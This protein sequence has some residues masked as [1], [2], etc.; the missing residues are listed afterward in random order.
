LC[1]TV[2][3]TLNRSAWVLF[4]ALVVPLTACNSELTSTSKIDDVRVRTMEGMYGAYLADHNN[5]PP[6]DE[7]AFRTYLETKQEN[8]KRAGLMVDEMFVSPRGGG[9]LDWGYGKKP[10]R[11][12]LGVTYVAYERAPVNGKRL[13]IAARG[14]YKEMDEA[15][16]RKI[17]PNTL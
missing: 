15:Q 3:L 14:A 2:E 9:P 1:E 8:L 6:R 17:F 4:A 5:Q 16:F 13:V 7:A 10:P 11:D 12:N